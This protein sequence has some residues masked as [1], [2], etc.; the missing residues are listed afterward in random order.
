LEQR[1][2]AFQ[3]AAGINADGI[4][5]PRTWILLNNSDADIPRLSTRG[6]R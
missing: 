6:Q 4:V 3:V 5:G 1:V 2:K